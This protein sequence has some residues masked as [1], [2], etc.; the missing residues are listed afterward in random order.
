MTLFDYFTK[1]LTSKY[2]QTRVAFYNTFN[3][4]VLDAL[5]EQGWQGKYM[6]AGDMSRCLTAQTKMAYSNIVTRQTEAGEYVTTNWTVTSYADRWLN[7]V[8]GVAQFNKALTEAGFDKGSF[9][10]EQDSELARELG[11]RANE[12]LFKL[13]TQ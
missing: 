5:R 4:N 8:H 11:Y 2:W 1:A 6:S 12:Y 7:N 9:T 10:V 13:N 3:N